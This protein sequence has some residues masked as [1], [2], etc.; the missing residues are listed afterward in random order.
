MDDSSDV[1]IA[2]EIVRLSDAIHSELTLAAI[3]E[4]SASI[5]CR[6][7]LGEVYGTD[8]KRDTQYIHDE[9]W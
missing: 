5:D 2:R 4:R 7:A 1:N 9:R 3:S 6:S 8:K